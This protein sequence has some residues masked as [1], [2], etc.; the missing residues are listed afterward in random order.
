MVVD[1]EAP[2]RD[3]T[4]SNAPFLYLSTH[5]NDWESP[6]CRGDNGK[7]IPLYRLTGAHED[8]ESIYFW[9]QTY[10]EYDAIWMGCGHLEIPV[11]CELA[12]PDSELSQQGRSICRKV[13]SATGIPT[14]YFLMRYWGRKDCEE[15]RLCPGCGCEW[16]KKNSVGQLNRFCDFTFM[17]RKCK[18]VSHIADSYDDSR[19]ARIGEWQAT[20]RRAK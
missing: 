2:Q 19:R 9:Q 1:D 14:Y 8:R 10:R 11:Y 7:P 13:E 5:M 6:L 20:K 15:K 18:L 12:L 3:T 17:C 16:H 4:W